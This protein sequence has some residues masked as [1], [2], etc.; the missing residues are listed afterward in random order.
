MAREY[1]LIVFRSAQTS[2]DMEMQKRR[3]SFTAPECGPFTSEVDGIFIFHRQTHIHVKNTFI[4]CDL[5][6]L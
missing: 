6:K 5:L 4:V 1:T 2:W 3:E